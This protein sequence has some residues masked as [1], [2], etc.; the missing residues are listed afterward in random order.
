MLMCSLMIYNL[1]LTVNAETIFNIWTLLKIED[2]TRHFTEEEIAEIT[3][4]YMLVERNNIYAQLAKETAENEINSDNDILK[5]ELVNNMEECRTRLVEAFTAC[6]TVAKVFEEKSKMENI[7][8]KMMKLK[9]EGYE[10]QYEFVENTFST[11][12]KAVQEFKDNQYDIGRVGTGIK[13]PTS[14]GFNIWRL[15]GS[16]IDWFDAKKVVFHPGIDLYANAGDDLYAQFNGVI[17]NVYYSHIDGNVIELQSGTHLMTRYKH[18]GEVSCKIGDVVKQYDKIGVVGSTGS[19]SI[20]P[21]VHIE[22]FL[23]NVMINPI[24]LYGQMGIVALQKWYRENPNTFIDVRTLLDTLDTS[25]QQEPVI[26]KYY[27]YY[28]PPDT[29]SQDIIDEAIREGHYPEGYKD[30]TAGFSKGVPNDL[31]KLIDSMKKGGSD[32][33]NEEKKSD[34]N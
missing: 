33:D 15:Q 30:T 28:D 10:I 23:D 1:N 25:V 19:N 4:N 7:V 3:K 9:E 26:I 27:G 14:A 16:C 29:L 6:D 17:R 2:T 11:D 21:H 34:N 22:M 32:S 5:A 13:S 24:L 20:G 12:Y 8:A 31:Q 18:V